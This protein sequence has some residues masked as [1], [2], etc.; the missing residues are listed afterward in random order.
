MRPTT[1]D[2]AQ[3]RLGNQTR[4]LRRL[5]PYLWPAGRLDLRLRV[6][7]ALVLL[8]LAKVRDDPDLPA[9]LV[10]GA[11]GIVRAASDSAPA[12]TD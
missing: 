6:A 10:E 12:E 7:A 11:T 4:T 9:L 2:P 1:F 5:L 8:V 3:F